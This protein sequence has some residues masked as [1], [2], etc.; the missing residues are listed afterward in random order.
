MGLCLAVMPAFL[1]SLCHYAT[2]WPSSAS[3]PPRLLGTDLQVICSLAQLLNHHAKKKKKNYTVR[4]CVPSFYNAIELMLHNTQIR[5]LTVITLDHTLLIWHT[6]FLYD[7]SLV[8][9]V[10]GC[11]YCAMDQSLDS[12][13]SGLRILVRQRDRGGIQKQDNYI[14]CPGGA[15]T[16]VRVLNLIKQ[17]EW[18]PKSTP[19]A[20]SANSLS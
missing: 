7:F 16:D 6:I 18:R 1:R 20:W 9:F 5:P 11:C 8:L 2:H 14:L 10:A 13:D 17:C 12:A 15:H 3:V 4:V 19:M